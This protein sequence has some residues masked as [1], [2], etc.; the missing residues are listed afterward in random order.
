VS[1][2]KLDGSRLV[3]LSACETGITDV[4][5]SPDEYLGLPAGFMQAG[6]PGVVSSLWAVDDEST[7]LLMKHF[8]QFHL[9]DRLEPSVALRKAQLSLRDNPKYNNPYYWAAFTFNGV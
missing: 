6:A 3:T 2:L 4:R 9:H 7:K 8:Y 1:E 5:Y